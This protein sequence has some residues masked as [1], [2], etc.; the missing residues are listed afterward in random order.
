MLNRV[1]V[2]RVFLMAISALE[3]VNARAARR[4]QLPAS[5]GKSWSDDEES[6]LREEYQHMPIPDI[7][8]KHRRTVRAIESRLVKLS[9]LQEDQ[10]TT[11][12]RYPDTASS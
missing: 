3:L 10:R 9:L 7:A 11:S 1:D 2:L 4:A 8:K 6:Q 5:V 12:N